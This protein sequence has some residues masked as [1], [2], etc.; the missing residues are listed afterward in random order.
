MSTP[1]DR[2]RYRIDPVQASHEDKE[3]EVKELEAQHASDQAK[4]KAL[5][6]WKDNAILRCDKLHA[7][8]KALV[9]ALSINEVTLSNLLNDAKTGRPFGPYAVVGL[10]TAIQTSR[11][12]LDV[13][14]GEN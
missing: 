5:T 11:T 12:A 2:E 4:I 1:T 3:K 7:E 10:T 14:K 6:E 8:K 13:A 9:A